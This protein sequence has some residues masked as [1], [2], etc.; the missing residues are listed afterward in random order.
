MNIFDELENPKKLQ[1]SDPETN[2]ESEV[3]V[4]SD[5]VEETEQAAEE[6]KFDKSNGAEDA[7]ACEDTQLDEAVNDDIHIKRIAKIHTRRKK[8]RNKLILF[9]ALSVIIVVVVV[10]TVIGQIKGKGFIA[11][12]FSGNARVSMTIPIAEHEPLDVADMQEDG[13]YTV[14]GLYKAVSDTVVSIMAYNSS[15]PFMY[16]GTGSGIVFSSDGYIVTNAHVIADADYAIKVVLSNEVE[17][18]AKVVGSDERSDLAVIKINAVDL[19]YASFGKSSL[20]EVGETVCAIGNPAGF[21]GSMT[22]GTVSGLNREIRTS[23]KNLKMDC[24]Q[25]DAAINP[26]NSGGALFNLWGEVV[27]VTSSRLNSS[28]Y[29]NMGFA[30][31]SE[32]AIPII[33]TLIENGYVVDRP[34]VGINFTSISAA[35]AEVY[36]TKPGILVQA[37]DETCDIAN[38]ELEIY[39]I[40]TEINGVQVIT[41]DDVDI[42]LEDYKPGDKCTAKVY[43]Y[44]VTGEETSFEISFALANWNDAE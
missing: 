9:F 24:I 11:N 12:L 43:R 2:S 7:D 30:I 26:G 44:S 38:T 36:V 16:S 40:I 5:S 8:I 28:S 42:A 17:Y 22:T 29:Q 3:S 18:A 6:K 23:S 14:S 10:L 15:N 21:A 4:N 25:I 31:S 35:M 1:N 19:S 20:L 13:R 27:G 32:E 41:S 39:D 37:I 33:E 34:R